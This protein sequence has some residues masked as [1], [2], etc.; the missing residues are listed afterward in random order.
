MHIRRAISLS[1][2]LLLAAAG[3]K[4]DHEPVFARVDSQ[5][6]TLTDFARETEGIPP[7][8]AEYLKTAAGK[9]ELLELLIRRRVVTAEANNSTVADRPELRR[10]LADLD[11]AFLRQ[12]Q[13]ARDRLI[14]GE[15]LRGLKEGP[16]KVTDADVKTAWSTGVEARASHILVS[17]EA[18]AKELRARVDK[19]DSFESLAK[20]FSE[21]PT[22]KK[23]G[24]LGFLMRGSLEPSF[25]EALFALKTGEVAGPLRT[26]YGFHIIK[27]TGERP[28]STRP[29]DEL[30]PAVRSM[31][32]NQ[33]F[34]AWLAEAKKR[35]TISMDMAVVEKSASPAASS[36]PQR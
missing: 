9:K 17:D 1:L 23:G 8:G 34:Q 27:K 35:H 20:E 5:P 26:P 21:D 25:E 36:I 7:S 32:E 4:K 6:I 30:A 10:K 14:V 28:L 2:P 13:E 12:R 24:D 31:L 11:A 33:R 18:K 29:E 22:G 16:L 19:G 15:F 3:C